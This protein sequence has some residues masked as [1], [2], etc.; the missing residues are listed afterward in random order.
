MDQTLPLSTLESRLPLDRPFT[1]AMARAS[2]VERPALERMLREG[3]VRRLLRGAYVAASA[4]E[5]TELRATAVG[6]RG[7]T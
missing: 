3:T 5:T 6:T 4:P 2:G 7:P 1:R